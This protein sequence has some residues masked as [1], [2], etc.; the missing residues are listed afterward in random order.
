MTKGTPK[1]L[2]AS[3]RQR[4]LNLSRQRR[5]DFQL[6]LT[7]YAVERLLFRVSQSRYRDQFVL[8]GAMLFQLWRGDMHRA[9]RDLD[10]LGRG[11]NEKATMIGVFQELCDT[12]VADDGLRFDKETVSAEEINPDDKYQ[13]V[14]V[15]LDCVLDKAVVRLQVDIAFGDVVT[16]SP[17]E[18]TYPT[19]LDSPAPV[20]KAY[21]K[22][23][24]VAEKLQAMVALGIANS[25][26]K[27]FFDIWFLAGNFGFEGTLLQ[28]A[29]VKT[30][31]RRQTSIP[32][33]VPLA[34]T[35]DFT[36][37][38]VKQTQWR[39]FVRKGGLTSPDIE[40]LEVVLRIREFLIPV[41]AAV[42]DNVPFKKSW[43]P[44]GGWA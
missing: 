3:V 6:V 35:D 8:K 1:N 25:R 20:L 40:L 7:R 11:S 9:T 4:L 33:D 43:K 23:S 17:V 39:G 42:R 13:G 26:M 16:P 19:V 44:S 10:L 12:Q 34:L 32:T 15:S 29:I 24:V 36:R 27:D 28:E 14:R 22:E 31:E 5:E 18:V 38:P 21:P 37:D 30:F 41:F 2:A